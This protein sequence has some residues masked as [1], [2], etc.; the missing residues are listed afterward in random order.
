MDST[1]SSRR[2]P[3]WL[4]IAA[5]LLASCTPRYDQDFDE[6]R[7]DLSTRGSS[8]TTLPGANT[9]PR[10]NTTLGSPSRNRTTQPA[11]SRTTLPGTSPRGSR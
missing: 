8:A 4:A 5:V 11:R 1:R 3:R 7:R 9:L 6:F 10:S 2:A